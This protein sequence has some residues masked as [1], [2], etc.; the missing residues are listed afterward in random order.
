MGAS[1]R[2][3]E[4][5]ASRVHSTL[6]SEL[7]LGAVAEASLR[8]L[9][10]AASW[11]LTKGPGRCGEGRELGSHGD[12]LYKA[13]GICFCDL[14]DKFSFPLMENLLRIMTKTP[15]VIYF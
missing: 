15:G 2:T 9:L 11:G 8:G 14:L 1:P 6:E 13:T 7:L 5:R 3:H 10:H 12:S 4:L